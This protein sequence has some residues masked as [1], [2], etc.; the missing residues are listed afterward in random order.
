VTLSAGPAVR[1]EPQPTPAGEGGRSARAEI[2]AVAFTR[3][4]FELNAQAVRAERAGS[5]S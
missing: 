2:Q 5:S 3:S 4:Q 1:R